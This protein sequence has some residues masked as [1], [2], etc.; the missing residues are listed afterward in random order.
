MKYYF[1]RV[2]FL[3][4]LV[5]MSACASCGEK[6]KKE[7]VLDGM[8]VG[9]VENNIKR[10]T[11]PVIA[12]SVP[13]PTTIRV[14][15]GTYYLYGTEKSPQQGIPALASTDLQTWHPVGCMEGYALKKGGDTYGDKG[16]WA[17]QVL[18]RNGRYYMVYMR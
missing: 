2:A 12:T 18:Y 9:G 3:L 16:F 4:G 7:I 11:N 6:D 14:Q 10:Y 15:D 1:V 5:F 8:E 17:P 13:D